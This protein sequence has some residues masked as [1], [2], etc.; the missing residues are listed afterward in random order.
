M[1][2]GRRA[3]LRQQGQALPVR[4]PISAARRNWL[5]ARGRDLITTDTPVL[6]SDPSGSAGVNP[7]RSLRTVALLIMSVLVCAVGMIVGF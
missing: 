7:D 6:D 5:Q 2:E 3:W 1:T 4:Q